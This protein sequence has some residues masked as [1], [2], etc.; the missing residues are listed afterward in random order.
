MQLKNLNDIL[1]E[2]PIKDALGEKLQ[3]YLLTFL[4]DQRGQ[5]TRNVICHGLARPEQMN[6]GLATQTLHAVLALALIRRKEPTTEPAEKA[7]AS[8]TNTTADQ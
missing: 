2:R 5:N 7:D 6:K 3:R 8:A 4:A 1:R